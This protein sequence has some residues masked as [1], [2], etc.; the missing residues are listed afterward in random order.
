MR[1]RRSQGLR[2]RPS[3]P[4][5]LGHRAPTAGRGRQQSDPAHAGRSWICSTR[6][7][8]TISSPRRSR[9]TSS[10]RRRRSAASS[11]TTS[12]PAEFLRDNLVMQSNVIHSAWRHGVRK[13]C[14][15]GSSCIYPKLA[16]QPMKEDY[17]ADRSAGADQRVVRDRQDRRHQDVPG[18]SPAVRLRRD[19]PD[20]DQSV[21]PGRQLRS[22]DIT[23]A[24]GADSQVP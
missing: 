17:A 14:F 12:Y 20:A 4:G 16:P 9:N 1:L 13:L 24:A 5:R 22:A 15:L 3:W 23:C 2:R 8:W 7:P 18:L 10:W 11:P 6:R 21:W 19:Q